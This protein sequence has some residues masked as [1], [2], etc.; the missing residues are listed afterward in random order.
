MLVVLATWFFKAP[1]ESHADPQNTPLHT[2]APWYFLWIQGALKLGDKVFWGIVFPGL[3]FGFLAIMPYI[4]ATPSR[5]FADRRFALSVS[6]VL[7][8]ALVVFTYWGLPT[9]GVATSGDIEVLAEMIP[10]EHAGVLRP[11]DFDQLQP[12]FYTTEELHGENPVAG[13]EAFNAMVIGSEHEDG[14][15]SVMNYQLFGLAPTAPFPAFTVTPAD[16]P[17][18]HHAVEE[19]E[20]L[21]EEFDELQNGYGVLIVSQTQANVKRVDAII[22][23]EVEDEETGE[24]TRTYSGD[25]TFIHENSEWFE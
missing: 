13:V 17:Q 11:I 6:Y 10:G 22:S 21:I 7:L 8:S 19:F 9:V 14:I 24:V 2:L 4:D 3:V 16:A 23:W 25:Y 20:H 12:G 1:L 18:L 5:R 15:R